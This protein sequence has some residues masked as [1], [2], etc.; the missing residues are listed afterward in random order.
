MQCRTCSK[1]CVFSSLGASRGRADA[2]R[3]V[4]D[5]VLSYPRCGSHHN[6][7][8]LTSIELLLPFVFSTVVCA[9][10]ARSSLIICSVF[11][12]LWP[13][14]PYS[15]VCIILAL[16]LS[17]SP[18]PIAFIRR[19]EKPSIISYLPPYTI[20]RT[21]I[22]TSSHRYTPTYKKQV[23]YILVITPR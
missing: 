12:L 23:P 15:L 4:R 20:H 21:Y 19:E 6:S 17:P 9:P 2:L 22:H 13:V 16:V 7:F 14:V 11:V 18:S 3:E 5:Y 8:F 10:R 1:M